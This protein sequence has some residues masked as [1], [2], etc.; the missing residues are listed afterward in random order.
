ML[1]FHLYHGSCDDHSIANGSPSS[2]LVVVIYRPQGV[3]AYR[4][5]SV[6]SHTLVA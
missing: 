5:S 6:V 3:V 4:G 2:E 1:I